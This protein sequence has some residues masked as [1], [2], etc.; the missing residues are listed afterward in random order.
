MDPLSVTAGILAILGASG[1]VGQA[2]SKIVA[3]K[4]APEALQSLNNEFDELQTV[5]QEVDDLLRENSD[6]RGAEPPQSL[7]NHYFTQSER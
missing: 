3:L 6:N 5:V 4:D 7:K 2:C 1:K